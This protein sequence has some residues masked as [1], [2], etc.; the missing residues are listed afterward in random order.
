MTKKIDIIKA[1]EI[2]L[3]KVKVI[4]NDTFNSTNKD[5]SF[6]ELLIY[7]EKIVN[8]NNAVLELQKVIKSGRVKTDTALKNARNLSLRNTKNDSTTF[9]DS[10]A[11]LSKIYKEI[12]D[13]KDSKPES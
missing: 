7:K 8:V 2:S 3:L 12:I 4:L 9:S 1:V 13:N 10:D 6:E 5:L 11:Q